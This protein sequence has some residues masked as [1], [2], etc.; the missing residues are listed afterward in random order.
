MFDAIKNLKCALNS[1]YRDSSVSWFRFWWRAN[2]FHKIKIKSIAIVKYT[3]TQKHHVT[4][5]FSDYRQT[6]QI[7]KIIDR[8]NIINFDKTEFRVKCLKRHDIFVSINVKKYYFLNSENKKSII[9]IEMINVVDNYSTL[10]MLIIQDQQIM[11]FWYQ[12]EF[13]KETL[14]IFSKNEFTSDLIVLQFLQHYVENSNS[15]S[16]RSWK[17][18]LMNNHDNYIISE[19]IKLTNDNHIRSFSLISHLTHCM[20]F[21]DVEIFQSY[22]HWHDVAIQKAFKE[23]NI[24]YSL[25]HFCHN[26]IKIRNNIFKS[27][28][29]RNAFK[30]SE[31][32][33]IDVSLCIDQLKKF[34]TFNNNESIR[35]RRNE[36]MI[37]QKNEQMKNEMR[38]ATTTRNRAHESTF[39]LSSRI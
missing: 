39:S 38:N 10:S 4:S 20:Q 5:W 12:D 15:D 37:E 16:L 13:S 26:F 14:C 33:S 32:W 25:F 17:L 6:F 18:M 1:F 34:K 3:T 21:L 19:F 2:N 11:K 29:I 23:F 36:Q 30:K 9:V 31:M 27:K 22:K 24:E 28:I 7:L 8:K 35:M